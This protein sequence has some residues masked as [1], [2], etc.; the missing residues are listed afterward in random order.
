ML[1][2][3]VALLLFVVGERLLYPRFS[4]HLEEEE[5]GGDGPLAAKMIPPPPLPGAVEVV[6]AGSDLDVGDFSIPCTPFLLGADD[7]CG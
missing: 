4:G 1:V 2:V 6:V 5:R 7:G 3:V